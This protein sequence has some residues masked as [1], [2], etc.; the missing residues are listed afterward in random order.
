MGIKNK[1]QTVGSNLSNYSGLPHATSIWAS[2]Q[3]VLHYAYSINGLPPIQGMRPNTPSPS[4]LSLGG[5][6]PF[7]KY[8]APEG[9]TF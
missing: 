3:S 8:V 5:A 4:N 2:K 9:K 6:I 7:W 1:L